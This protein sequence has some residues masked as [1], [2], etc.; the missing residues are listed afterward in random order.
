MIFFTK[1]HGL[2]NDYL[3]INCIDKVNYIAKENI[4]QMARFMSNRHFGIGADGIILINKSQIADFKMNI[5]NSDG[6]EAQMCGNGIRCFAKYVYDNKFTTKQKITIETLCGIKT[7]YI[8]EINNETNEITIEMGEPIFE[9]E[10]IPVIIEN[11]ED[12][13]PIAKINIEIE[14]VNFELY[15]ISMGNPHAVTLVDNVEKINIEKIGKIIENDIHYPE[16]TNV[17]FIQILDKSTIKMRVWERGTGETMACGT[18]S[19]AVAVIC[20]KLGLTRKN[21]KIQLKG[22]ELKISWD[23]KTNKVFM[24]GIATKVFEG[25][26]EEL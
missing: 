13:Q 19:C 17:E 12:K 8:N 20:N 6:S 5:Y 25:A 18:G 1:M 22:G 9:P 14:G 10:K 15:N 7:A 2:G 4:P 21:S 26:V 23:E 16:K 24:T 3:F 11:E